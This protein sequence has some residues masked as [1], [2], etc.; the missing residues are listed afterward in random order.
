VIEVDEV[1]W[2]QICVALQL[3]TTA[4]PEQVLEQAKKAEVLAPDFV[5][6][7]VDPLETKS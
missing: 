3:P 6:G 1:V 4:T 7:P 2:A 5:M